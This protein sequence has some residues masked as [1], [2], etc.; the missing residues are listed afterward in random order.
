M[1]M[2]HKPLETVAGV[3]AVAAALLLLPAAL[4]CGDDEHGCYGPANTIEHV[5]HVKRMQPGA[6]DAGYGPKRPLEWGQLNF[7]HTV[8]PFPSS[9]ARAGQDI[10]VCVC[11]RPRSS[12]AEKHPPPRPIRMAGCRAT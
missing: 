5:R 1:M 6:P 8:S 10:V 4:A 11:G 9:T 2:M 3:A 12:N 7:L